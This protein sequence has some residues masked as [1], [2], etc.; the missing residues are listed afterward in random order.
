MKSEYD[1][2]TKDKVK[3]SYLLYAMLFELGLNP[4]NKGT[5]YIKEVIEYIILNNLYDYSYKEILQLFIKDKNYDL[6]KIRTNI[7]NALYRI[8]YSKAKKNFEKYLN[9]QFDTYYLSPSKFINIIALK[10]ND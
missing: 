10:C 2:S 4:S 1:T 3:A 5:I 9:I 8:D 6:I 7:K